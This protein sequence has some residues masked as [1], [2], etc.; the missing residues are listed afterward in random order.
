MDKIENGMHSI[1]CKFFDRYMF[2]LLTSSLGM[3]L[4]WLLGEDFPPSITVFFDDT[5][6]S[7]GN[8]RPSSTGFGHGDLSDGIEGL[9]DGVSSEARRFYRC[10]SAPPLLQVVQDLERKTQPIE[11]GKLTQEFLLVLPYTAIGN[12]IGAALID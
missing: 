12:H 10:C 7:E 6:V 3:E 1:L 11:F 8:G 4:V 5:A 9:P 2:S